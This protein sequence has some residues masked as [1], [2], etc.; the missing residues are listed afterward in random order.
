MTGKTIN[1]VVL[2]AVRFVCN[3][4]DVAPVREQL[5]SPALLFG[6]ELLDCGEH[7]P[8]RRPLEEGAHVVR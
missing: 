5:V 7:D 4:D 3:D 1:E 2:G 8:A 6:A